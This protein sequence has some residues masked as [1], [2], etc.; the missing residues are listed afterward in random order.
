MTKQNFI[1]IEC[2]RWFHLKKWLN[3]KQAIKMGYIDFEKYLKTKE[4]PKFWE[5][6]I[7]KR[8]K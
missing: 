6:E 1:E 7:L 4:L 3:Q 8:S 2:Y 5:E